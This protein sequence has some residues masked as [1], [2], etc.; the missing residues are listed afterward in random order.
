MNQKMRKIYSFAVAAVAMFAAMSCAKEIVQDNQQAGMPDNDALTFVASVDG[1]DDASETKS[2]LDGLKSY[3]DGEEKIW[4][5]DPRNET[6]DEGP[7]LNTGW[8]KGFTAVT[9]KSQTA[10]FVE[11]D[12]TTSFEGE[13][14]MA[15][16]P[17]DLQAVRAGKA[18]N[19]LLQECGSVMSRQQL[20]GRMILMRILQSLRLLQPAMFLSSR[21]FH[22][23]SS[24]R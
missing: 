9:E 3:W 12:N 17:E 23:F 14:L 11:D 13:T 18:A 22:P 10:T 21:T 2:V 19:L 16:Y 4:I 6:N 7:F 20:P 5:L 15:V 1:A 24:S 8:K